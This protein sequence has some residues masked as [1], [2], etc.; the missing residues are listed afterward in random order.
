MGSEQYLGVAAA[1]MDSGEHMHHFFWSPLYLGYRSNFVQD[2]D[3]QVR[4][5][6][7]KVVVFKILALILCD[8]ICT[9][10]LKR[11]G[12]LDALN[13]SPFL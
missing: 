8:L 2:W 7:G 3:F 5:Q 6:G 12:Y 13:I 9:D 10:G 4:R 11:R 1:R